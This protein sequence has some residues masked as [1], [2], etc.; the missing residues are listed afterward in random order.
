MGE[1]EEEDLCRWEE[2]EAR[3]LSAVAAKYTK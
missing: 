3:G 2:R 1:A